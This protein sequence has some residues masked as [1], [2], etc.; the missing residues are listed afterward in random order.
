MRIKR[1]LQSLLCLL[2]VIGSISGFATVAYAGN[3]H[4]D[5][6]ASNVAGVASKDPYSR[7]ESKNDS[8]Q[9]FYIKLTSLTNG[10]SMSFTSYSSAREQVSTALKITNTQLN[11][12]K[13]H[14]YDKATALKGAE[15]YV[16]ATAPYGYANVHAVGTYCP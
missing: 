2:A 6:S 3:V 10:P 4:L 5:V 15:Y 7:M 8:E 9:Y 11:T 13:K 1:K 12:T 14:L 16:Y